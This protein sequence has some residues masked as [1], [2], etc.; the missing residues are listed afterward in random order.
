MQPPKDYLEKDKLN[1]SPTKVYG[2]KNKVEE[3]NKPKPK[4]EPV[5]V[6]IDDEDSQSKS[7]DKEVEVGTLTSNSGP[8]TRS[9]KKMKTIRF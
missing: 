5:V 2:K 6:L 4:V 8:I 9:S 3:T 1:K 7:E